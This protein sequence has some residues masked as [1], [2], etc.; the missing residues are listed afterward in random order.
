MAIHSSMIVDLTIILVTLTLCICSV[1]FRDF[2]LN[3]P[4][5]VF[6]VFLVS[7]GCVLLPELHS[8]SDHNFRHLFSQFAD[9]SVAASQDF[10]QVLEWP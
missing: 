8:S 9:L 5:G 10:L 2:I 4:I 6:N 3:Y 7:S 1:Q